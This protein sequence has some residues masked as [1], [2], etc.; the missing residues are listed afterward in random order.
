MEIII[1][2]GALVVLLGFSAIFMARS[3]EQ[4]TLAQHELAKAELERAKSEREMTDLAIERNEVTAANERALIL[5]KA[6]DNALA[7]IL[8]A[9]LQSKNELLLKIGERGGLRVQ[10]SDGQN[11]DDQGS[12]RISWEW[13][14]FQNAV[15]KIYRNEGSIVEDIKTLLKRANLVHVEQ[16]V[17][18]GS[19]TD[20]E[21]TKGHTYNYYAF[22]ETRR[23]GVRAESI[24]LDLPVE[25]RTGKV[26]DGDGNEITAFNTVQPKTYEEPFYDGFCY[27]RIT[28]AKWLDSREQRK[29]NLAV[30]REDLEMQEE[31]AELAKLEKQVGLRSG[32]F[33]TDHIKL[34]ISE[35]KK[36][37]GRGSVIERAMK[38]LDEED[39]LD[40]RQREIILAFIKKQS[41]RQ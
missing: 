21:A 5:S 15:V 31:E 38:L 26:I 3:N 24:T 23:T 36:I 22:I 4:K 40:E 10:F 35:A 34:L 19:Y 16:H 14:P 41:Y 9:D 2:G 6:R 8:G 29:E 25:V 12:P 30:R 27:R 28:V 17:A 39:G 32:D 37:S 20:N 11:E 18:K 13:S 33:G 1:L 7:Q